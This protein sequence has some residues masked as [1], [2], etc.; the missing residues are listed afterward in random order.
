M[1]VAFILTIPDFER[2]RKA[3]ELATNITFME[4][5][6]GQYFRIADR[7]VYWTDIDFQDPLDNCTGSIY[8]IGGTV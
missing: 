8:R 2:G 3:R 6:T 4:E 1:I 7:T 5:G